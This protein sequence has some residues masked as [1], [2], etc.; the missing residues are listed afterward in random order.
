MKTLSGAKSE[1][2]Q[3]ITLISGAMI[4]FS[5]TVIPSVG[6][7]WVEPTRAASFVLL[8]AASALF[9]A[10]RWNPDKLFKEDDELRSKSFVFAFLCSLLTMLVTAF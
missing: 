4:A 7:N 6:S 8:V 10:A 5:L 3:T 1:R 2:Q 9:F